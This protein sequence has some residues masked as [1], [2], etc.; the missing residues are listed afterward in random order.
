M[1]AGLIL[2]TVLA[3]AVIFHLNTLPLMLLVIYLLAC[4]TRLRLLLR[5]VGPGRIGGG[6]YLN[7]IMR[8]GLTVDLRRWVAWPRVYYQRT[9]WP[10]SVLIVW[11]GFAIGWHYEL[12]EDQTH[13]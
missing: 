12:D 6:V 11:L 10:R 7:R 3:I 9:T 5:D 8:Y 13:H 1:N 2:S 4:M